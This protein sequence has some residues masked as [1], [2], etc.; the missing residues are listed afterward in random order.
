[1]AHRWQTLVSSGHNAGACTSLWKAGLAQQQAAQ[2]GESQGI[3]LWVGVGL[4]LVVLLVVLVACIPRCLGRDKGADGKDTQGAPVG[5]AT[6]LWSPQILNRE[7]QPRGQD[8]RLAGDLFPVLP[9]NTFEDQVFFQLHWALSDSP[10]AEV[11]IF[12]SGSQLVCKASGD[13]AGYPGEVSFE[14]AAGDQ[15]GLIRKLGL[16]GDGSNSARVHQFGVYKM[17]PGTDAQI[18]M[19]LVA[20]AKPTHQEGQVPVWEVAAVTDGN[21]LENEVIVEGDFV[22]LCMLAPDQQEPVRMMDPSGDVMAQCE[23]SEGH[24]IITVKQS[25]PDISLLL[26]L[27]MVIQRVQLARN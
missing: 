1:M 3:L 10:T 22:R 4:G 13:L 24:M 21:T 18:T 25:V 5:S 16:P 27:A 14:T 19:S 20:R 9:P 23:V 8:Y 7:T 17:T 12:D 2:E 26:V 15:W 11:P 6:K